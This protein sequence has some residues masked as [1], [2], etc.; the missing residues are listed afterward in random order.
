MELKLMRTFFKTITLVALIYFQILFGASKDPVR[1]VNGMVVSASDYAS[2]IGLQILMKGGNA[3]DAAVATGFALSVSYPSAGNIGGGGFFVI[4]FSDGKQTT[5][6]FREKAPAAVHKDIYLDSDGNFLPDLSQKGWTS[7]GVPGSPAGLIFAHEK[8]GSL[9]FEDLIQP[10]IDLARNGIILSYGAVS[11]LNSVYTEFLKYPASKMI[12]TKNGAKYSEGDT[13][14]QTDLAKTLEFI[15]DLKKDGFYKGKTA[16]LIVKQSMENGG[17]LTKEDLE[18]YSPVE[19]VPVRGTYR[20]YDII[21]MAPPSSGGVALIEAL[22]IL[23]NYDLKKLGWASSSYIHYIVESLKH[24]YADRSE[25]LGDPDFF[26]VPADKLISKTYS[27][28][29]FNLIDE[30]AKRP[31]EISR[32]TFNLY[33]SPQTTHYSIVDKFGNAVSATVTLNSSYGNKIVVDGAGFIMNNEMDDFS[34]KPGSPNQFGLIGSAANSI[35][36]GKRML[37][38]MTPTI[39]LQNLKPVLIIGS[40]GGS[41]IITTVLQVVLNCLDFGM[42][43]QTAIDLGRFHNQWLPDSIEYEDFLISEDVRNNLTN[44]GHKFGSKTSLGRA[45][46]ILWDWKNKIWTGATDPRGYGKAVGY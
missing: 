8:Y 34:S 42:D 37:S 1:G 4:H 40:P 12:F 33:E 28:E 19:R 43:I 18:N 14:F 39:I 24:V 7:S 3:V 35:E 30:K 25:Y 27:K 45:E 20:G 38:S 2:E 46:G 36:P 26:D 5:I 23:E 17:Y 29:L 41:T 16:D 31:S 22:N 15:R 44:R 11:S 9:P 10:A 6:D 21:S 13:L 32:S